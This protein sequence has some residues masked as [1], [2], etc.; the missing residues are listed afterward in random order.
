MT[1]FE[2][3]VESS[4]N[5]SAA[6]PQVWK[7][8]TDPVLLPKLTPLLSD[9][10]VEG[11]KWHW[12]MMKIA[13]LGVSVVPVFTETMTFEDQ[14]RI[15]YAHTPPRGK[16]ERAGAE[17]TYELSDVEGGT[18]LAIRLTLRVDLPL[19]KASARAVQRV[20]RKTMERTGEKFS[21]NLLRHLDAH[22]T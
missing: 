7:A 11:D 3:T 4:A 17:G 21:A 1:C 5:I 13:A 18:H 14:K 10:D 22:E 8:L 12:H 16:R 9:I 2:A 20:M 6:R 19:P 15:E